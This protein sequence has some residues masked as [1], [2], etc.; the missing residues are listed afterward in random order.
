MALALDSL[1]VGHHV[2]EEPRLL[3]RQESVYDAANGAACARKPAVLV[4]GDVRCVLEAPAGDVV[5]R[6]PVL[7]RARERELLDVGRE[8]EAGRGGRR[9]RDPVPRGGGRRG[10]RRRRL[11]LISPPPAARPSGA[12]RPNGAPR[13]R[14]VLPTRAARPPGTPRLA[15]AGR[16]AGPR[17]ACAPPRPAAQDARDARAPPRRRHHRRAC[18][19]RLRFGLG[20][21]RELHQARLVLVIHQFVGLILRDGSA[22]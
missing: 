1:R 11:E 2:D 17:G 20:L 21:A 16:C 7:G 12:R 8:D 22:R 9:P 19:L 6:P 4:L 3:V 14:A 15:R 13:P 18:A 5:R 10:V